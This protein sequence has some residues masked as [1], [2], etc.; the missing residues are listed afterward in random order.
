MKA[1]RINRFGGPEVLALEEVNQPQP[2]PG[3]VRV[4]SAAIG[5]N[6]ID[7]RM[8]AG[9]R[10][11]PLPGGIGLE[12]VGVVDKVGDDVSEF[13]VGERVGYYLGPLGSYAEANCVSANHLVRIPGGISDAAAVCLLT[14]AITAQYLLHRT[15]LIRPGQ[16]IMVHAA[17]GGVG[18][19]LTQ[20]AH[21]I[22]ANVI[23]GVGDAGKREMALA[24][25]C[26]QVVLTRDPD[27]PSQVKELSGGV[28]VV[29]DSVGRD[30]FDGSISALR[31]RGTYVGFGASSG[32]LAPIDIAA[33]SVR[34]SYTFVVASGFHYSRTHSEIT[35][36]FSD[37][38]SA[39]RA[40]K[41]KPYIGLILPLDA[42]A[43][44]H[45]RLESRRTMG[46]I[47][48]VP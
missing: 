24:N 18:M 9:T 34:G 22:G 13:K 42:A 41:I 40:G 46:S 38:L 23:G 5:V 21:A 25:G 26:A 7:T 12:A 6:F 14:K 20:W 19:F 11:I 32:A 27:W 8:R 47:V 31:T 29:Y 30:T 28:D 33:L 37:V 43:E 48:L 2:A 10:P 1:V 39:Y 36:G 44:A 17:A 15:T 4:I 35:E 45:R 3:Q 16:T